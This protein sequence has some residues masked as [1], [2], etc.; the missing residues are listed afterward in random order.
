MEADFAL[1][2]GNDQSGKVEDEVFECF[3]I[4]II[5][6]YVVKW[7]EV[8]SIVIIFEVCFDVSQ[9]FCV[10]EF[11]GLSPNVVKCN[12]LCFYIFIRILDT[13]GPHLSEVNEECITVRI[14]LFN[15]DKF[16]VVVEGKVD[17]ADGSRLL[18]LGCI[19]NEA[20]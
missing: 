10:D 13:K 6:F 1:R 14:F 3:C 20:L 4:V 11:E 7:R 15:F 16:G 19:D 5:N 9:L 12:Q 18:I 17:L 8:R 2:K